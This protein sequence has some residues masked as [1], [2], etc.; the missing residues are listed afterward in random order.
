MMPVTVPVPLPIAILMYSWVNATR[1]RVVKLYT[2][3][4]NEGLSCKRPVKDL[5]NNCE[6][7][8]NFGCK[9]RILLR[10]Q[11]KVMRDE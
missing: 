10:H 8:V 5:Y 9:C 6:H 3:T 2:R 1:L 4:K 7:Q 11:P